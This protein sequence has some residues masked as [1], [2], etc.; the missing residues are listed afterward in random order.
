MGKKRNGHNGEDLIIRVPAGT[1]VTALH[2]DEDLKQ[3]DSH[4]TDDDARAPDLRYSTRGYRRS[5]LVDLDSPDTRIVLAKGGIGGKGNAHFATARFQSPKFCQPGMAGEEIVVE[6]ELK[7]LADVGLVG[8]PNAGKST[9][10]AAISRA[11]PKIA[12]YPFT[13]LTVHL[14][15]VDFE[16]SSRVFVADIPGLI[17][18]AHL[19]VGLGHDFLRHVE[20]TK[21]LAYVLDMAGTDGRSPLDDFL[22]LREEVGLYQKSLLLRPSIIVA[23]KMDAGFAAQQ[24]LERLMERV[25]L[26]VFPISASERTG[27]SALLSS[28][29]ELVRAESEIEESAKLLKRHSDTTDN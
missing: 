8:Y 21:V 5:L 2:Q 11:K 26:P 27:L 12:P 29:K 9:L 22:S 3:D 6:L 16:D 23:N 28:M 7:A 10:L 14:G 25:P 20:R 15:A 19:N 17:E 4:M 18:G 1:I 24:N 13:T